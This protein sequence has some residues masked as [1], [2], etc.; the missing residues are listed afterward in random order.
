MNQDPCS[1]EAWQEIVRNGKLGKKQMAVLDLFCKAHPKALSATQ[2]VRQMG[3]GVSEN[4]R[5]RVTELCQRGFLKKVS[6]DKCLITDQLVN[7]YQWTGR[8]T[9][10]EVRV[11]CVTCPHCEGKGVTMKKV[12]VT[13]TGETKQLDLITH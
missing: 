2:I 1:V 7:F 12:P 10:V 3:R 4:V 6:R 8:T 13:S 11:Q 9:P 5:N